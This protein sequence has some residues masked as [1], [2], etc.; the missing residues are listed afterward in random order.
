MR[1][2]LRLSQLYNHCY[3]STVTCC[4]QDFTTAPSQESVVQDVA[5][6]QW[7]ERTWTI[8]QVKECTKYSSYLCQDEKSFQKITEAGSSSSY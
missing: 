5:G 6:N 3:L 1:L 4:F 2:P 7:V 8:L